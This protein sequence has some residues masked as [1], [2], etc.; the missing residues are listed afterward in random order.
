MQDLQIINN[1]PNQHLQDLFSWE[2]EVLLEEF[3]ATKKSLNTKKSYSQD[4]WGFFEKYEIFF[5]KDFIEKSLSWEIW[6]FIWDY[7]EN[8][9]KSDEKNKN[10]ILNPRTINRKLFSLSSFYNFLNKKY[11]FKHNPTKVFTALKTW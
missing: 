5:V 1:Q 10:R 4:L 11:N 6:N 9:K 2:I 7:L 8:L 3:L